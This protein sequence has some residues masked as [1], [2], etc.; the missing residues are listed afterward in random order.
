MQA[1]R[2]GSV[3]IL[4][5]RVDNVTMK[6]ALLEIVAMILE[7]GFHQIATAN[8]NFLINAIYDSEQKEILSGCRM[9]LADGM[10]LVWASRVMG[11][12]LQERV[13]G[14]DLVPRLIEL[15]AEKGYR[16]F[17]LG[18]RESSSRAVANWIEQTHPRAKLVGRYCPPFAELDEMDHEDMLLKI[19]A[20]RPDI[21]LVAFGN[22]KQE[23]W[24]AMH[25]H[26]LRVPVCI[27]VGGSLDI[28]AGLVPRAPVWMQNHGLEWLFR[29]CLEPT[30]LSLRYARDAFGLIRY[31]PLQLA[32]TAARRRK[33]S[34]NSIT[35]ETT[36]STTVLHVF[37]S[38]TGNPVSNMESKARLVLDGRT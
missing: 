12:P 27:G 28:L 15:S 26:R 23:K 18:A 38:L 32:A 1:W 22:P 34:P 24:L 17:L 5:V 20:A 25:R 37:G 11:A 6:D 13:T 16:I 14:S 8:L 21:L 7:G 4:G 10:P 19:E 33:P 29:T 9:V 2:G 30:R 36:G 35:E 31:M 3:V